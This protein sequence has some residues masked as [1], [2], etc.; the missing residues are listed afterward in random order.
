MKSVHKNGLDIDQKHRMVGKSVSPDFL[1]PT[2]EW[3]RIF[4]EVW[5][6]FLLVVVAA[7]GG[8]MVVISGGVVTQ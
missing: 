5:G 1:D 3:R 6:T 7:G 8:I 4:A 2:F